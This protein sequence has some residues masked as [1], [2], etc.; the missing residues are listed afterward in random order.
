MKIPKLIILLSFMIPSCGS[1]FVIPPP[2]QKPD[3]GTVEK[4]EGKPEGK[5]EDKPEDTPG[6]T[7]DLPAGALVADGNDEATYSLILKSGYNYETPDNSGDHSSTPYRHIRQSYD[8]FLKRP[9]FDFI[10]HIKNDDDRGKTNIKDRQRN[11]IKTDGNS[12]ASMVAQKGETLKMTWKFC[13]P[14]GMKTTT[15]FSHVH[16]L[17]GIDNKEANADVGMPLITFTAR[18][19][20]NGTQQFQ[21]IHTSPTSQG[22]ENTTLYKCSLD[23]FL[24]QWVEVDEV[25]T[26]DEAGS[27]E[28]VIRRMS[29]GKELVK[30]NPRTLWLW[31]DGTTGLRPKWGLYRNFGDNRSN[32]HLLRDETLKFADFH[33]QKL[34]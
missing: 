27:Y 24:G 20:S 8:S 29:D 10:L 15:K 21:V 28:L 18:S 9:V 14:V 19:M 6:V 30:V 17:K 3:T 5:P 33:I 31:R 12:P 23:D 16:Q 26:F 25:V 34:K 32:A 13:L 11:E 7:P 2:V 22:S 4:P 1:D